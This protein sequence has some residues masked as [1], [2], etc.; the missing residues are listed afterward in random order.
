MKD[1]NEYERA[2]V[3]NADWFMMNQTREGFIDVEGDE[4]YGVRGDATL[5]GHSITVR[6]Y[7]Y[8]L[9]HEQ[10]YF[11]SA[12][13]SLQ[14]LEDRQDEKGGWKKYAAFTLDGAQCVFEGFNTFQRIS[15][16]DRFEETLNRSAGRMISG[17]IGPKGNL[18]LPNI[19]EIGEYAH[20]SLL[21]WK[22]VGNEYFKQSAET[23]LGH[24]YRNF[25]KEEGY[26]V[27]YDSQRIR[28]GVPVRLIRPG[29]RWT[30]NTLRLK[31]RIVARMADHMLPIVVGETHP[32][33]S[34][35]MMDAESLLDTLDGSCDFPELR[36]QTENAIHWVKKYCSGPFPGS[37]VESRKMKKRENTFP[38]R[39]I[40]DSEMAALWPAACLL[41]AYC[42]MN[43]RQYGSEA[44]Q[45]ADWIL[46]VQDEKGGFH[47]F[48]KPDGT[49]LPLQSGNVNFYASMALWLYNEVYGNGA[50]S[51]FSQ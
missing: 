43:D 16:D 41:L 9:T 44:K 50:V 3:K 30:T 38:I 33:Y 12:L 47:N 13:T 14:W 21:A 15:R 32:Q 23:I 4:F 36:I 26:W 31:G 39:L 29:I 28:S 8:A 17:T 37:V 18:L 42:G 46:S 45:T 48:Q 1:L 6:M 34:M 2:I 24:I 7:A 10:T 49:T 25:D 11:D 35:N 22:T 27:P 19:I 51:L 5:I 40:N 20:F